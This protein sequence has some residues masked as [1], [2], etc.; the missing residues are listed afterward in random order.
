MKSL[1]D[2]KEYRRRFIEKEFDFPFQMSTGHNTNHISKYG[3]NIRW[4]RPV[5]KE[6]LSHNLWVPVPKHRVVPLNR[7]RYEHWMRKKIQVLI[8]EWATDPMGYAGVKTA[9]EAVQKVV[10]TYIGDE[11]YLPVE[12]GTDPKQWASRVM[13]CLGEAQFPTAFGLALEAEE[14]TQV[15]EKHVKEALSDMEHLGLDDLLMN[16]MT[17]AWTL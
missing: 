5:M 12:M 16:L 17:P 6:G 7:E 9:G 15:R 2:Y 10:Q 11:N 4:Y 13:E 3:E 8:D 14:Y 1:P